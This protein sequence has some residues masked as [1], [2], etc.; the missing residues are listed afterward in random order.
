MK[1]MMVP[2]ALFVLLAVTFTVAACGGDDDD[3]GTGESPGGGGNDSDERFDVTIIDFAFD[4]DEFV[5]PADREITFAV[6]NDDGAGHTF[7]VYADPDFTEP[8]DV[9]IDA[10]PGQS[11]QG[12]GTFAAGDYF[13]RCD[14]HPSQM[15]GSFI[16]E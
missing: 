6:A 8:T 2:V 12:S 13:F 16:A 3:G 9:D 11:A 10:A 5:V 7:T 15:Q 4:P 1:R 14:L